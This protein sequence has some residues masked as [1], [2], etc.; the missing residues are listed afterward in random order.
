M[1]LEKTAGSNF[2]DFR[3]ESGRLENHRFEK[4]NIIIPRYNYNNYI[5]TAFNLSFKCINIKATNGVAIFI[6]QN[7]IALYFLAG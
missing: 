5:V 3:N 7:F 6:R 1:G 4:H 2:W